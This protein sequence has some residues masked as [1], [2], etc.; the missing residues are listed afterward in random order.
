[1]INEGQWKR[2][3]CN[4]D[5]LDSHNKQGSANGRHFNLSRVNLVNFG[6]IPAVSHR[7]QNCRRRAGGGKLAENADGPPLACRPTTDHWQLYKKLYFVRGIYFKE[8]SLKISHGNE[9]VLIFQIYKKMYETFKN[10]TF[11]LIIILPPGGPV[12]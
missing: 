12:A 6:S 7:R 2:L 9:L 5:N 1:M 4:E 8:V 11:N 3:N 10:N